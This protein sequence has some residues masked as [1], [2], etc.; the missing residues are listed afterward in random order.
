MMQVTEFMSKDIEGNDLLYL[1]VLTID[2]NGNRHRTTV[3][4]DIAQQEYLDALQA[5][6]E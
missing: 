3:R 6:A 5:Q 1:Q 4:K 2:E